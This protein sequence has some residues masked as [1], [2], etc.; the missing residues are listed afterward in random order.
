MVHKV[1]RTICR[2]QK[3]A[4]SAT[5]VPMVDRPDY[6]VIGERLK[7]LRMH[8]GFESQKD[9]AERNGFNISQYNHWEKG[10]RRIPVD[11]AEQLANNYGLTLDF[12]YRGR[13]DGLP[14]TLSKSL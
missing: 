14:E 2:S 4:Q 7:A 3:I 5:D 11:F 8:L 9:W 1:N 12:I 10:T 13:R 6:R